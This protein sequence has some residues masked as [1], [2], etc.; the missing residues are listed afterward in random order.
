MRRL[1]ARSIA[2]EGGIEALDALLPHS[3]EA[4]PTSAYI[5]TI[6]SEHG[7]IGHSV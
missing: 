3:R 1:L 2:M 6:C 5:A 4:A 7:A